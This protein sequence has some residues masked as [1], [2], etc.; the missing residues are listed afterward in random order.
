VAS[1]RDVASYLLSRGSQSALRLQ[2][3]LYY[4]QAWSLVWD[5][6]SLF[7]ETIRAWDMGPVVGEVWYAYRSHDLGGDPARLTEAERETVDAVLDYYGAQPETWLS[8][9]SHRE[10]PWGDAYVRGAR[11]S[12]VISLDAMRDF[13]GRLPPSP[14]KRVPDV[15]RRGAEVVMSLS[16]EELV[17]LNDDADAGVDVGRWLCEQV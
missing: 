6:R 9:L 5:G 7:N 2:K 17:E 1:A 16:P 11:P 4:A 10:Q 13:Y 3:L 12:R 15:Y 14:I 8:E